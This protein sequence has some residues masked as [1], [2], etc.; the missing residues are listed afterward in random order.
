[1]NRAIQVLAGISAF[2]ILVVVMLASPA[3]GE[4]QASSQL[5]TAKESSAKLWWLRGDPIEG[6]WS[7][8]VVITD[9]GSGNPLGLAFDAMSV[10]GGDGTFHDTNANTLTPRSNAFGY[11]QR[12]EGNKYRFAFRVFHFD[13]AGTYLGYQVVRHD[14]VLAR[15]GESY[16]SEGT[17]EFFNPDGTPRPPVLGCSESTATRFQ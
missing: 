16:R 14:V 5:Q 1:M 11:W 7:S 12:V 17:A 4:G 6:V 8:R 13:L 10:F 3:R 15:N 9:C 2:A